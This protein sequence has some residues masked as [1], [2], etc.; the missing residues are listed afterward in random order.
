MARNVLLPRAQ[1][2]IAGNIPTTKE[3][4]DFFQSLLG[5]SIGADLAEQ[6]ATLAARVAELEQNAPGSFTIQGFGSITVAGTPE[7][8]IVQIYLEGDADEPGPRFYYGTG[9]DGMRG[10]FRLFDAIDTPSDGIARTDSGYT[11]LGEVSTPADL[12][13]SGATGQAW[14]VIDEN[15]GLYAWDGAAFTIDPAADG[16]VGIIPANDLAAVEA[17]AGT[18]LAARTGA[19]TWATRTITAGAGIDV[20]NG[21]GVD[22]DP[23]VSHA[24][25]SA[26]TDIAAEFTG[27][28]VPW[29]IS[30]TFDQFGHV[31][32]RTIT[33]REIAHNETASLQGGVPGEYYHFT[34]AEHAGLLNWAEE[35][36]ADYVNTTGSQV[37]IAGSKE[38]VGDQTIRST[39]TT[40]SPNHVIIE[41]TSGASAGGNVL[42]GDFYGAGHGGPTAIILRRASGTEAAPAAV[43]SGEVLFRLDGTGH[44]GNDFANP[45]TF[46]FHG[47]ATQAFT[48]TAW[49]TR[50]RIRC[51]PQNSTSFRE[52]LACDVNHNLTPGNTDN[53]L[54]N[55][56]AA[57]RWSVI[58]AGTGAINTSDE[59]EKTP[60]R[61][62]TSVE[63]ACAI[64][65]A[66]L[67]CV[68]K[69]LAAVE[70]KGDAARLH[71][72]PG[73][74]SVIAVMER[75]G[76]DP[77][78]YGFVC[79]D[80][81]DEQSELW[82]EWPEERDEDGNV[83]REAGRELVQPYRAAGD[84]YS[85]RSSELSWFVMRGQAARQDALEARIAALEG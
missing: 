33:E 23:I 69:W 41:N 4:Y 50:F 17:L 51:V 77:F 67:P 57:N 49:G 79:Y 40:S 72:G 44:D 36:P 18:G 53:T 30:I 85:L 2:P 10:F 75:H 24:D 29:Q 8:G 19:E 64:E 34:A 58:Y 70:E 48:P 60:F 5:D 56:T 47:L 76:L 52:V 22:S 46:Q 6:L 13:G 59:R 1:A 7:A 32:S 78:A 38:W 21:D 35:V 9:P 83:V 42:I 84:R 62:M 43:P 26:V 45:A 3:W 20:D 28:A 81:W 61:D 12:P 11:I 68:Y 65:L 54:S 55:G 16:L 14:R 63:I 15:P 66:S 71:V 80:Q 27:S 74:Q 37:D 82:D 31:L 25:T 73:V 39:N